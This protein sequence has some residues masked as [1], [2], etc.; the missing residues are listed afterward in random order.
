MRLLVVIYVRPKD[1]QMLERIGQA[2]WKFCTK[3]ELAVE[4][5][6]VYDAV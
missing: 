3:L 4:H 6:V 5:G 2:P 1:P